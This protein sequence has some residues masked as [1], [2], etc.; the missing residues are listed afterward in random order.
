MILTTT[1][2][3]EGKPA[4]EYKG[5]VHG[6]TI[7]G[8]NILRDLMA[9]VR[10]VFGGRS[11]AYEAELKRAREIALAELAEEAKRLGANAVVGIDLDYEVIGQS[12]LMV[13]ATGTAVRV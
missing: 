6:E 1:N 3:I 2:G 12:M 5:I 7:V 9:S 8:A 11:G 10:D 13:T 4:L